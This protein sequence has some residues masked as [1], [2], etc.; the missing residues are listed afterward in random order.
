MAVVKRRWQMARK[1]PKAPPTFKVPEES[2][3]YFVFGKEYFVF[4]TVLIS[5]SSKETQKFVL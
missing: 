3:N 5:S 2:S 1:I 4:I